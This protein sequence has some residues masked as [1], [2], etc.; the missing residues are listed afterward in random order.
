VDRIEKMYAEHACQK[1]CVDFHVLIDSYRHEEIPALFA[2]DAVFHHMTSGTL[3]G[4]AEIAAYLDSKSTWPV[5]RHLVTNVSI[6]VIDTERAEGSVYL[7]VF[8]A[9]PTAKPAVLEPPIVL[10]TYED[11]FRNTADGWK[12]ATR[13]PRITH[14]APSF[15]RLINTKDDEKRMRRA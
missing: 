10:V 2:E 13:R 11:T 6:T 12:F 9:E 3:N 7:T 14:A 5:V 1:L 15:T 8:Y 4:R